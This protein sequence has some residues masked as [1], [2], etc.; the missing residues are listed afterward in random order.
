MFTLFRRELKSLIL[1]PFTMIV[2]VMSFLVPAI[3]FSVFLSLGPDGTETQSVELVYAGFESLVSIVALFFAAVIPI[4]VIF[5]NYGERKEKN[6]N[7]LIFRAICCVEKICY[8][9]SF[10]FK[11]FAYVTKMSYLCSII[12]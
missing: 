8:F 11:I 2:F 12:G 3:I 1:K 5:V 10:F 6:Y 7:F 4:V 9:F